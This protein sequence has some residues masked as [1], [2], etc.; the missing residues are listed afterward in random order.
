MLQAVALTAATLWVCII[1]GEI[2]QQTGEKCKCFFGLMTCLL[3]LLMLDHT[4]GGLGVS[5]KAI[6]KAIICLTII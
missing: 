2:M 3:G 6:M 1:G 5:R 4:K